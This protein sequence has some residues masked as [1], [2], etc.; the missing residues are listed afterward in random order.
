MLAM[1]SGVDGF[2]LMACQRQP[3]FELSK[4]KIFG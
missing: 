2:I 1:N 3:D 4:S